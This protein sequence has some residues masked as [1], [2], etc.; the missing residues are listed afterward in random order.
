MGT[1]GNGNLNQ[2]TVGRKSSAGMTRAAF[3]GRQDP[4]PI[5]DK[6][7]QHQNI[8]SLITYLSE[9]QCV[10][11][12]RAQTAVLLASNSPCFARAGTTTRSLRR[13]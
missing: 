3:G 8:H 5:A 9:H 12:L 6:A 1:M 13:S 11:K 2:S 10:Q 4:R 7:Y